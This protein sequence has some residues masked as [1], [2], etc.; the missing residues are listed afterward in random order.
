MAL[1]GYRKGLWRGQENRSRRER[2]LGSLE[3]IRISHHPKQEPGK[4]ATQGK[5][6]PMRPEESRK[7]NRQ[8]N[9]DRAGRLDHRR[10]SQRIS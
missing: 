10:S 4:M 3:I 6:Q 9:M 1:G 5:N 2:C 8:I 7:V